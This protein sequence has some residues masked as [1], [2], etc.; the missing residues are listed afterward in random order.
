MQP[1]ALLNGKRILRDNMAKQKFCLFW[2]EKSTIN[3]KFVLAKGSIC[4]LPLWRLEPVMR[5]L[6]IFYMP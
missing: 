1:R 3:D 4:H 2:K 6:L 5:Q